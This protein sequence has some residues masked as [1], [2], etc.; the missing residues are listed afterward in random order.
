MGNWPTGRHGKAEP[1]AS[2]SANGSSPCTTASFRAKPNGGL[3]LQPGG[4]AFRKPYSFV[5]VQIAGTE[6]VSPVN[7]C[8]LQLLIVESGH[9]PAARVRKVKGG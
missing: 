9:R 7:A 5:V 6:V 4:W 3:K 8:E 2:T 1:G